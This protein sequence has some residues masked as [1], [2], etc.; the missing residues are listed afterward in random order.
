M[1]RY[2]KD[3][4]NYGEN[5]A[6][7]YLKSL[8]YEII[9]RNFRCK[10]GEIDIIAKQ[11]TTLCFVE[12]KTRHETTFGFPAEAVNSRKQFKIY[13]TSEFYIIKNKILNLNFRFDVIEVLLNS[14]TNELSLRLIED[15]FQI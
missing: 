10:I 8:N 11:G 4:G 3:I 7:E 2:N 15:A 1:H 13:K 9:E 12:V 14:R 5:A 6:V